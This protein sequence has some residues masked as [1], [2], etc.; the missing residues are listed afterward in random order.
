ME[1]SKI[2]TPS[3]DGTQITL[4]KLNLSGQDLT[5]VPDDESLENI[6]VLDVSKNSL[7]SLEF[8]NKTP[9]LIDLDA[10]N[11]HLSEEVCLFE[12]L[13]FI[14]KIN[15]SSNLFEHLLSFPQLITLT[16]LDLSNN[17][18]MY[19]SQLPEMPNLRYLDLS[20]NAIHEL[21]LVS[22]PNLQT[23]NLNN[24]VMT[25]LTL[26]PLPS[27]RFLSV[28]YNQISIIDDFEESDLPFL[29][30]LDLTFN[31]LESPDALRSLSKLPLLFDLKVNNNPLIKEDK[32]HVE[33]ILVILPYLTELN[34]EI[35]NAKNKVKAVLKVSPETKEE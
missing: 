18:L 21:K 27:L 31:A 6:R 7:S 22:M 32:S 11:N 30:S 9:N 29:C 28:T 2:L 15:L 14:S 1:E 34:S 23:L 5:E 8:V 26:P 16:Y 19:A 17:N 33:P 10:S 12:N 3:I 13:H 20:K 25:R 24:N 35:V 4:F